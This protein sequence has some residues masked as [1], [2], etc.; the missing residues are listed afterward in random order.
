[1][2][3]E[4]TNPLGGVESSIMSEADAVAAV[5]ERLRGTPPEQAKKPKE[6][7]ENNPPPEVQADDEGAESEPEDREVDPEADDGA[8]DDEDGVE[9]PDT[10]EALAEQHKVDPAELAGHLKVAVKQ[11]DGTIKE[12]SIAELRDNHLFQADYTRK[13]Q[14]L[15]REKEAFNAERGQVSQHINQKVTQLDTLMH[16]LAQQI[17]QGPS[18]A[19]LNRL[20]VDDPAAFVAANRKREQQVQAFRQAYEARTAQEAQAKHE[21]AERTRALRAEQQKLLAQKVPELVKPEEAQKFERELVD[22]LRSYGY[23]DASI[24]SFV[25]GAFDHRQVLIIRDAMRYRAGEKAGKETRK[26]LK[27]LPKVSKPGASVTK[28]EAATTKVEELRR[29]LRSP[30]TRNDRKASERAGLDLV[31]NLLSKG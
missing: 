14:E 3:D 25:N 28:T 15:A 27:A 20:A 30:R 11:A 10:L 21:Q 22:G 31:K 24:E 17:E 19:E 2:A 7:G 23:S 8:T 26:V 18:D 12:V 5:T 4:S 13:T 9:F 1:M 6:T 29:R 16:V